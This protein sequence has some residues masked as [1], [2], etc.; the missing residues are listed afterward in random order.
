VSP[1]NLISPSVP[2]QVTDERGDVFVSA[3]LHFRLQNLPGSQNRPEGMIRYLLLPDL[4]EPLLAAADWARAAKEPLMTI[5]PVVRTAALWMRAAADAVIG[6]RV[7]ELELDFV[8]GIS[9]RRVLRRCRNWQRGS[10]G[11]S[12]CA[13][14]C[15]R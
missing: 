1:T 12:T 15:P 13:I 6:A 9:F 4:L 11:N 14:V 2:D 5:P 8:I 10:K 3:V 7:P